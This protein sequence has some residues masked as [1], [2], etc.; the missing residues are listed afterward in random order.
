VT[1][2]RVAAIPTEQY[3]TWFAQHRGTLL[4]RGPFHDPAWLRAVAHGARYRLACVGCFADGE[5]VA[6]VPGFLGR[7]GPFRLFGSPLGGTLTSILGPV[8]VGDRSCK[9]L[10]EAILACSDFAHKVWGVSYSEFRTRHRLVEPPMIDLSEWTERPRASCAIDLTRGEAGLWAAIRSDCRRMLRKSERCGIEIVPYQGTAEEYRRM[11]AETLG[12]SGPEAT[13]SATFYG[14]SFFQAL[15]EQL[16]PSGPLWAFVARYQGRTISIVLLVHDDQ[17]A[18]YISG[19][20]LSSYRHLPTSYLLHWQAMLTAMRAGLRVYD[21]G[22][23]PGPPGSAAFK[24][25]FAPEAIEYTRLSR[26][27]RLVRGAKAAYTRSI[28]VRAR[29]EAWWRQSASA[30]TPQ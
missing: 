30:R 2:C 22:S 21:F 5:L 26:A 6:A 7:R 24:E 3:E 4:G 29:L 15:F 9:I 13:A 8:A 16:G 12:R 11:L 14:V 19:A 20:S 17:E 28:A 1:A 23:A 27:S 18:H 10:A 25:S